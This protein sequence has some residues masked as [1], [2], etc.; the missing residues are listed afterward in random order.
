MLRISPSVRFTNDINNLAIIFQ[1]LPEGH[2]MFTDYLITQNMIEKGK[3]I[4]KG[5]FGEVFKGK[6]SIFI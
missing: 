4:G 1:L 5:Q 6:I 2:K 3:R